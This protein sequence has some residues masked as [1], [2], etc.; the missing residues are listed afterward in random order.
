VQDGF[1]SAGGGLF[2]IVVERITVVKFRVH[3]R[4]CNGTGRERGI[5]MASSSVCPSSVHYVEVSLP[6]RSI[7]L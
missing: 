7:R 3:N 1:E 4:G 6:Y 2:E 5:D